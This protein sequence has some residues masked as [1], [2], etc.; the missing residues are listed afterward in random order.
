MRILVVGSGGREHALA[1]KIAQSPQ[2]TRLWCAPGNPGMAPIADCLDIGAEDSAS[3]VEFAQRERVDLTVVGPED[4]LA[5]G[6][7]DVFQE[8]GLRVFGPTARAAE[9]ESSKVFA[10]RLFRD[11]GIPSGEFEVFDDISAALRAVEQRTPPI[12]IKADGLARGKG[13]TV[14][15]TREQAAD[16]LRQAMADRVFGDAGARVLI[17]EY[18]TGPEVTVMAL[19][20]G[21]TIVPLAAAQDHKPIFDGDRGPNTGGMGCYSPVP[22]LTDDFYQQAVADIIEPT[23]AAMRAEG[24][25]Y[26]G[27]LYAGLVMTRDGLK[28]LEF[29]CRFGDPESQVVLPRLESDLVEL[30]DAAVDGRLR[31]VACRWTDRAAVCVVMASGG[32]PGDYEK[33]KPISGLD[34]VAAM[35]DVVVFH[36]G[37][38]RAA[39]RVVTAGGR[40]LGVTALGD[41]FRQ[42]V[43]RAYQAVDRIRFEGA[44]CRRDIAHQALAEEG[45]AA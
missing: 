9:L 24:R 18:L 3:L 36:A 37:T 28:V 19:A 26:R 31:E 33:G 10:K 6:I 14:A 16:A 42:A 22:M 30:L 27:V 11:H 7:V 17:D 4:P 20:D 34:A 25:P 43:D 32:Y 45:V 39:D 13:V 21:E 23:A 8:R 40:V 5:Q 44:H 29:N 12:V 41:S 2:L 1:W 15:E 38:R 35:D